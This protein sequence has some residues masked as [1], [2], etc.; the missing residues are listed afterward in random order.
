MAQM[1]FRIREYKDMTFDGEGSHGFFVQR[2]E[3]KWYKLLW[4]TVCVRSRGVEK[5]MTF[6]TKEK[7]QAWID[8]QTLSKK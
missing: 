3:D 4:D 1:K 8:K 2:K 6:P 7:A 5:V